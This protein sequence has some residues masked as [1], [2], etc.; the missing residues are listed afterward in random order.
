[1][2]GLTS[3]TEAPGVRLPSASQRGT[4]WGRGRALHHCPQTLCFLHQVIQQGPV[5]IG[6]C[7]CHS[8]R[9]AWGGDSGGRE[10]L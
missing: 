5:L 4:S 3:D 7:V 6:E 2:A 9:K 8:G 10:E 1:M